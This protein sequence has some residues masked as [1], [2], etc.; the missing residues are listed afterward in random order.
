M[1]RKDAK[2]VCTV[3]VSLIAICAFAGIEPAYVSHNKVR[4]DVKTMTNIVEWAESVESNIVTA[5]NE[6]LKAA[7]DAVFADGPKLTDEQI[8]NGITYEKGGHVQDAA[9]AIGR[10]AEAAILTS[11]VENAKAN[12]KIRSVS[13]AIGGYADAVVVQKSGGVQ[14][15]AI[16]IGYC[17]KA[18]AGNAIA[19]GSGAQHTNETDMSS[20]AT[21]ANAEQAVAFGYGAKAVAGNAWQF[22]FGTNDVSNSL[23]FG[24]VWIVKDNK[25]AVPEQEQPEIDEAKV[26]DI[27]YNT[28]AP[29]VYGSDECEMVVTAKSYA[30]TTISPG[31]YCD[32]V[33]AFAS[34]TRNME[35]YFP[36]TLFLRAALPIIIDKVP[37]DG[38]T[39]LGTTNKITRLPAVVKFK[40]PI[41]KQVIV[42]QST[43]DDGWNW[44]PGITSVK[45]TEGTNGMWLETVSGTNLQVATGVRV[46][47]ST[48]N[49]VVK[50]CD[51]TSVNALYDKI[52]VNGLFVSDEGVS[53]DTVYKI[54]LLK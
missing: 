40:E 39:F 49:D 44:T 42:E 4:G 25:L 16:A 10:E 34:D 51:S 41:D 21:V 3:C 15:Q 32:Q 47:Y 1:N 28:H 17:A 35:I 20:G 9:I 22:G 52:W 13:I 43:Y 29:V 30:V 37:S 36:N 7:H 54:T 5:T 24:D 8:S 19:I 11:V 46:E 31:V 38:L 48:K 26:Q 45:W 53:D 50:T 27:V 12:S 14:S 6:V 2:R 23:K 33:E 18:K